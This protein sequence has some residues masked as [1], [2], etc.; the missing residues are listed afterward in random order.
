LTGLNCLLAFHLCGDIKED[1]K[2]GGWHEA[3]QE[4]ERV[5]GT[6]S[7]LSSIRYCIFIA[8]YGI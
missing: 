2:F 7:N 1:F 8:S 4:S 5:L 6:A 3:V